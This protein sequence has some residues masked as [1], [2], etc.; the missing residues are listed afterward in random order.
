M[1]IADPYNQHILDV[2]VG[3]RHRLFFSC[4]SFAARYHCPP[5]ELGCL[6]FAQLLL[7]GEKFNLGNTIGKANRPSFTLTLFHI[8][9]ESW[10]DIITQ[11]CFIHIEPIFSISQKHVTLW[12]SD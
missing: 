3:S 12:R 6:L 9:L 4:P 2:V 10:H 11:R 8:P 1:I 7:P 5:H